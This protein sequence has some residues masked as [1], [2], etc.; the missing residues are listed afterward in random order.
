MMYVFFQMKP[1]HTSCSAPPYT[2]TREAPTLIS[3]S[4]WVFCGFTTF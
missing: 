1:K 3:E 2:P 4:A